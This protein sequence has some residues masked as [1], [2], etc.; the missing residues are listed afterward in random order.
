M[1]DPLF[2]FFEFFFACMY[3]NDL[4]LLVSA[5]K[6][7][8]HFLQDQYKNILDFGVCRECAKRLK[9]S[10]FVKKNPNG[11]HAYRRSTLVE[12]TFNTGQIPHV[13]EMSRLT[14]IGK[15]ARNTLPTHFSPISVINAIAKV[16]EKIVL[17]QLE[18]HFENTTISKQSGFRNGD[19]TTLQ[20]YRL[21][22]ERSET[23]D[24]GEAVG[25]A[26][27]DSPKA[28]DKI[29]HNGLLAKLKAYGLSGN[30]YTWIKY[31][32]KDREQRVELQGG[33]SHW[34][35]LPAGVS[36]GL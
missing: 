4:L 6:W 3:R 18:D 35:T 12:R 34:R 23:V 16:I 31:Y 29:W 15:T 27:L 28:L 10:F 26:F 21:V 17:K 8:R 32:I 11:I 13:R 9:N 36:H 5:Y 24:S 22:Q 20:L 19:S 33:S 1:I 14:P 7:R 25:I 30:S 2:D